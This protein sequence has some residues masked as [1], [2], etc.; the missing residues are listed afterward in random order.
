VTKSD[1]RALEELSDG[2]EPT[3]EQ[4]A[5]LDKRKCPAVKTSL[6]DLL[7]KRLEETEVKDERQ[8]T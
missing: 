4:R 6:G 2:I 5:I 3:D 8:K 7:R 1:K